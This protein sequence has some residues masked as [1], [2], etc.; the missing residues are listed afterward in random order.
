MTEQINMLVAIKNTLNLINVSGQDNMQRILG[1]I[2]A[3]DEV[4]KALKERDGDSSPAGDP[5]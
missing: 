2:Q 5:S 1:C 3:V 4:V